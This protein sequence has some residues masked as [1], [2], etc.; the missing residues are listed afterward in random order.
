M[1]DFEKE[2]FKFPDEQGNDV[3]VTVDKDNDVDVEIVD[4]TP[5]PD[6]GRKPLEK[7]PEEVSDDELSEY[8][9]KVKKRI[10]EL[11]HARHDERR[12]KEAALREQQ[13]YARIAQQLVEENKKL[14]NYV[15]TG[16]K[17]YATTALA[18]AEAEV[19]AAK[20][21]LKEAHENFDADQIVAAQEMLTE[22]KMKVAEAKSFKPMPLQEAEE[23]VYTEQRAAPAPYV[24]AA[25]KR[26]QE[27]NQWF[28]TDDEMTAVAL[29]AHKQL[30]NSGIDPQK[31]SEEYFSQID[32][33][34]KRRFPDYF[35]EDE[36]EKPRKEKPAAVVAPVTRSTGPKKIRLTQTQVAVAKRL[37]LTTEQYA[38]E[39]AKLET[40]NG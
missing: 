1:A 17:A 11:S 34:I 20:A 18:A 28:G 38:R 40:A 16:E 27:K 32:A 25:T 21:K 8:S 39:L 19:N 24:D 36:P 7:E 9:E 10:K 33:R 3:T 22:A 35:T 31:D 23:G 26:W 6:R 30:V 5:E 12:A 13:E 2:E 37:G 14:K 4:D 15:V 29:I